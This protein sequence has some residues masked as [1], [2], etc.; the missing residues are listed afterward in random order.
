MESGVELTPAQVNTM[1]SEL[2]SCMAHADT[3]LRNRNFAGKVCQTA[4]EASDSPTLRVAGQMRGWSLTLTVK[5]SGRYNC[6]DTEL[7][8]RVGDLVL[9][10][11]EAF[12]DYRRAFQSTEW[13]HYWVYFQTEPRFTRWLNW[14][15]LS[16]HIHHLNVPETD[17]ECLTDI[18]RKAISFTKDETIVSTSL[19]ANQIEELL[20]RCYSFTELEKPAEYD[21]RVQ[22]AKDFILERLDQGITIYDVADAVGLSKTRLSA[23]F[24]ANTGR[25]VF[26]WRDE[27]RVAEASKLLKK[28]QLSI[29]QIARAT[30]YNDSLYFSKCFTKVAKVSPTQFRKLRCE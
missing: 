8:T 15:E 11:P 23:L 3:L 18:F 12:Y 29:T 9:H 10:S 25:T 6:G 7:T 2:R 1:A 20:I 26:Q 30:G 27:R 17:I 4:L 19:L 16:P 21:V 14:P 13:V 24:K 28:T 22:D 5:G